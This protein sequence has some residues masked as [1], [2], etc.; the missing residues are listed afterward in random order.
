[1]S[2]FTVTLDDRELQ[3][4][5]NQ[6]AARVEDLTP[7]MDALGQVLVTRSDLSFRR[8]ETP[9]GQRWTPL[10]EV[11]L[12]RR[13]GTSAQIL[14]DTG[15]LAASITARASRTQVQVGTNVVYAAVHQFGNPLNQFYNTPRGARAPIPARP[16]LPIRGGAV[17]LPAED[18]EAMLDI[19]RRALDQAVS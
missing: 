9:W 6:L 5:L 14:R 1:V 16:F 12:E 15:R 18:R 4:A 11:T 2:G 10:S 17:D 8:E 3:D 7:V 19:V 13:R